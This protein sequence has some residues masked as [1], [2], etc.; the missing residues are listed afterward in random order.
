MLRYTFDEWL[1]EKGH[2]NSE[3]DLDKVEELF[4]VEEYDNLH[5]QYLNED[6]FCFC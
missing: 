4:T 1:I 2:I 3:E 6:G 5:E